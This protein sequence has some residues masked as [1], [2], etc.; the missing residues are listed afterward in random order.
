ML[1]LNKSKI[2]LF[3]FAG[4][5]L[6]ENLIVIFADIKL[7]KN[8]LVILLATNMSKNSFGETL[9]LTRRHAVPLVTFFWCHHVMY[10]TTC[11]ASGHLVIYREC[12]G[13]ERAFFTRRCFLP[14]TPSCWFQSFHGAASSTS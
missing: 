7:V 13:F 8:L 10:R 1:V 12:Y 9:C 2:L 3:I 6:I 5:K 14:Y 4:F 11:H